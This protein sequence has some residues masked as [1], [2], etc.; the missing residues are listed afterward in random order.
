MPA[1]LIAPRGFQPTPTTLHTKAIIQT[2]TGSNTSRTSILHMAAGSIDPPTGVN[3]TLG[4]TIIER[5]TGMIEGWATGGSMIAI[6]TVL[7]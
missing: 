6:S 3:M 5:I 1:T 2:I 4:G 7:G